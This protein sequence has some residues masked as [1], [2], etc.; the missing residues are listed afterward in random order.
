MIKPSILPGMMELL[1]ED[2]IVFNEIKDIIE[3]TFKKFGFLPLD[4]P[5]ME[6]QEILFAKGGGET[7]KQVYAFEKGSA[8]IGLRYD[9]TVPLARYVAQYFSDLNFPFRRYHIDKV[10]RGERNQRGRYREFYQCDIDI[11]GNTS[12]SLYNDA[13]I[14]AV[15]NEVFKS[16]G[17]NNFKFL[18][19]NRKLLN[20]F[21]Q[22]LG[23]EDFEFT[24]RT[25]DKLDKIGIENVKKEF[26]ERNVDKGTID[27]LL[28]F[29]STKGTNSE[30]LSYLKNLDISNE[31]FEE[32]LSELSFVYDNM[33]ALGIHDENIQISLNITRGLDYYTGSVYETI[34]TGYESIGS[35]C[36]GGRY[37]NLA[38]N[39]TKQKLPGVGMSIGL[40]RLF[41]QLK[42]ANLLEDKSPHITECLIIPMKGYED[43]GIELLTHLRENDKMVQIYLEGGKLK[44]Q[45]NYADK[46]NVPYTII[47]G[48][49][50]ASTGTYS[51][52]DMK[53][54]EQKTVSYDELIKYL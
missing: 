48:E 29:I 19:N 21:F 30:I 32:G 50:E 7:S 49:E 41:Y 53:T 38:G 33:K 6:K 40:T 17:F 43:K 9:L 1:P 34:L 52:R 37:E 20:G 44:K 16:L 15:M 5:V 46:L 26:V 12:L 10:Y 28:A 3:K 18:F 2:Q 39:Y 31:L 47:I 25:I 23:L 54:G 45:F 13:E 51:I 42:E 4:T 11:V 8:K 24:L 27:K 22:S 14:P 35:I 36:S